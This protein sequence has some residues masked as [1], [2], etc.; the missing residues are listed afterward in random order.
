MSKPALN[1]KIR[2]A[3]ALIP[4]LGT[5]STIVVGLPVGFPEENKLQYSTGIF[6]IEKAMQATNHVLLKQVNG[7][8]NYQVFSCSY[9]PF[10][11][12]RSSSCGDKKYLQPYV[13]GAVTI[14]WY[15]IDKFLGFTNDIPQ[16]VSIEM[17]G[18]VMRSYEHT[19]K[20]VYQRRDSSFYILTPI[21]FLMV[22]LFYWFL[23]K[24]R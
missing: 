12:Q 24:I 20:K 13:D 17:N 5:L 3:I 10:G 19:A 23:G 15:K 22:F 18:E 16:L 4:L 1:K 8:S 6:D 11:N 7:S 2:F 21:L 9:S 14:G